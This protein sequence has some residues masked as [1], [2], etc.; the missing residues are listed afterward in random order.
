MRRATELMHFLKNE[1]LKLSLALKYLEGPGLPGMTSVVPL[2]MGMVFSNGDGAPQAAPSSHL[3]ICP[4]CRHINS[5]VA[6]LHPGTW[7][8]MSTE[9]IDSV[10][11]THQS[12]DLDRRARQSIN[13][14]KLGFIDPA[15]FTAPE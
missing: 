7:A 5:K 11:G 13:P 1:I 14:A 15:T 8:W 2:V 12:R 9:N 3:C 6:K 10:W 4:A